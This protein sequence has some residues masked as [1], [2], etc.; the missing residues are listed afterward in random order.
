LFLNHWIL[1]NFL[2]LL[3]IIKIIISQMGQLIEKA[4]LA[5]NAVLLLALIIFVE[6]VNLEKLEHNLWPSWQREIEKDYIYHQIL[7]K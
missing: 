1:K 2:M 5:Y 4:Q 3:E 6:K 7:N